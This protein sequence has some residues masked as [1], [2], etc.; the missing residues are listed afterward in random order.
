MLLFCSYNSDRIFFLKDIC[1]LLVVV[2]HYELCLQ[3]GAFESQKRVLKREKER[4][5]CAWR[6][7]IVKI[8]PR[9]FELVQSISS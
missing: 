7:A 4:R 1:F 2:I 5:K 9:Y 3:N 6:L 8:A